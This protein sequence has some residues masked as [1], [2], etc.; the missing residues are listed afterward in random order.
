V[1]VVGSLF[2]RLQEDVFSIKGDADEQTRFNRN[3]YNAVNS[4]DCARVGTAPR[5]IEMFALRG[6][7]STNP[8]FSTS[9]G[10]FSSPAAGFSPRHPLISG[11]QTP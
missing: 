11:I 10:L 9:P 7:T 2:K 4:P 3:G 5:S 1:H 6:K 8:T